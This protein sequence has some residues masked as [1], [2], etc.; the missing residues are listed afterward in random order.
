MIDED[1]KKQYCGAHLLSN[2]STMQVVVRMMG[3]KERNKWNY[4]ES[5]GCQLHAHYSIAFI[6]NSDK[7]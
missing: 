1:S 7:Q 5:V 3:S 6:G 2:I 4:C